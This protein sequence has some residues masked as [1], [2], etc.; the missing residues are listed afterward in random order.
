M[1]SSPKRRKNNSAVGRKPVAMGEGALG[2]QDGL[3]PDGEACWDDLS[4]RQDVWN[5]GVGTFDVDT[6]DDLPVA[7]CFVS[8]QHIGSPGADYAA[9]RRDAEI[10]RKSPGMFAVFGGDSIDNHIKHASAVLHSKT[11]PDEQLS[12]FEHYLD[13][14]GDSVFAMISGNHDLWSDKIAGINPIRRAAAARKIVYA[15]HELRMTVRHGKVPYRIMVRHQAKRFNSSINP[16]HAIKQHR[17]HG[18]W[19]FDIGIMCHYH[20]AG[21]EAWFQNGR[22]CWAARPGSYLVKDDHS[23]EYGFNSSIPKCPTFVLFSDARKIV[24]FMEVEE[25]SEYLAAVRT[26]EASLRK[27]RR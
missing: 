9:M 8:D 17:R 10:V 15:K 3:P 1:S 12:A 23:K 22:S 11:L 25:A 5:D 19:E 27:K 7:V 2:F 6:R 21:I 26:R 13:M 4:S 16:L 14:F 24:P 20:E 18:E